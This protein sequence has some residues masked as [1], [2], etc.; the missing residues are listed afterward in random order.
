LL[1]VKDHKSKY[2]CD[3]FKGIPTAPEASYGPEKYSETLFVKDYNFLESVSSY[4]DQL[5]RERAQ[6]NF[7]NEDDNFVLIDGDKRKKVLEFKK[8]QKVGKLAELRL[9]PSE[10]SRSRKN[11]THLVGAADLEKKIG[12]EGVVGLEGEGEVKPET[13]SSR[14]GKIFWTLD[15]V[16]YSNGRLIETIF[17]VSDETKVRDLFIFD[18]SDE[19]KVRDLFVD[20]D[21][22]IYLKN[23]TK[24]MG[25]VKKWKEIKGVDFDKTLAQVLIGAH[26]FEYPIVA[27]ERGDNT[28]QND[29]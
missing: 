2:K 26:I 27:I 6:S 14:R 20:D 22:K 3:G 28:R 19:T 21:Q 4:A 24:K 15:F 23:E 13:K 10:F 11:R 5:E 12:G 29:L 25:E 7:K 1:C 17:D 16:E 18:V 9:L 8:I